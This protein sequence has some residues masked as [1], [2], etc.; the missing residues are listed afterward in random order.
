MTRSSMKK[1]RKN[2]QQKQQKKILELISDY[3]K[4]TGY[5]VNTQRSTTFLYISNER[6]NLKLKTCYPLQ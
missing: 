1:I 3:S 2:Q 5:K 6:V 4:D